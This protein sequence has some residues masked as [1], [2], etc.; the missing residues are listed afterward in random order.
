MEE[1]FFSLFLSFSIG[2]AALL[3]WSLLTRKKDQSRPG[4]M[5]VICILFF[6]AAVLYVF[7][8]FLL[9]YVSSFFPACSQ[10]ITITRRGTWRR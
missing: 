9:K 5:R 6:S 7:G 4:T 2:G 1:H 10:R 8:F 3:A